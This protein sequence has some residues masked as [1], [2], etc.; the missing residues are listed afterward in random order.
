MSKETYKSRR[1]M[2]K[3]LGVAGL[4]ASAGEAFG[5]D[6]FGASAQERTAPVQG[7]SVRR[8]PLGTPTQKA[9]RPTPI[10]A[11]DPMVV[12][13]VRAAQNAQLGRRRVPLQLKA[14][15]AHKFSHDFP[16]PSALARRARRETMPVEAVAIEISDPASTKALHAR[17]AGLKMRDAQRP[18]AFYF[19]RAR[20][21][22]KTSAS[23][24]FNFAMSLVESAG[25]FAATIIRVDNFL[26]IPGWT[27]IPGLF[28]GAASG[29][30]PVD[31]S[32]GQDTE[33]P[34][35]EDKDFVK[36]Y[37]DALAVFMPIA[38]PFIAGFCVAC[39]TAVAALPPTAGASAIVSIPACVAC[40]VGLGA[41]FAVP[42]ALCLG[43]I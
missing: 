38:S 6:F 28:A 3:A 18:Q 37:L 15:T 34:E 39:G 43:E 10:P 11:S 8:P 13:A 9:G 2:L 32:E 19:V 21:A 14:S 40:A 36:C 16:L 42:A 29:S 1:Q 31:S 5:L 23:D 4:A 26:K 17:L 12:R 25:R 27:L 22:G 41:A 30:A 7:P 20:A 24:E 35:E 33:E